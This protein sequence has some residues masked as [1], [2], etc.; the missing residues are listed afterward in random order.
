MMCQCD[1]RASGRKNLAV[2]LLV[3]VA[4]STPFILGAVPFPANADTEPTPSNSID[5]G[6]GTRNRNIFSLKSPTH[7]RGYQ[8]TVTSTA[9][10]KT[11]VQNAMC[12][13]VTVCNIKQIVTPKSADQQNATPPAPATAPPMM[14]PFMYIGRWGLMMSLGGGVRGSG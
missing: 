13:N 14:G 9:G 11:S 10:G 1:G 12:R 6:N 3:G 7:S 5:H 2:S 8:H 4:A